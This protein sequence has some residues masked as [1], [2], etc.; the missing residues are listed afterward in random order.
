MEYVSGSSLENHIANL[1]FEKI[2][3]SEVELQYLM[4]M[5]DLAWAI[6]FLHKQ[7]V[8][9]RDIKPDN[10]ILI[11]DFNLKLIDFGISRQIRS[12]STGTFTMH[13]GTILYE[14][15]ENYPYYD[16]EDLYKTDLSESNKVKITTKFDVWSFGLILSEVFSCEKPY[17]TNDYNKICVKLISR[18][19]Y[20]V[21]K[22]LMNT[23][24]GVL[25]EDCTQI[26]VKKRIDIQDVKFR[27]I[28]IFKAKLKIFAEKSDLRKVY[29]DRKRILFA[30]KVKQ[31]L[32]MKKSSIT[33]I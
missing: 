28:D 8:I 31:I 24:I 13:K 29:E 30:S 16:E 20:P 7:K 25:I 19:K 2:K 17:K 1:T 5:I 11:N 6:E 23:E 10:V 15:P 22:V 32:S 26:D 9:H 4:L 14:P 27:L 12:D 18:E 3:L 33:I 21:P